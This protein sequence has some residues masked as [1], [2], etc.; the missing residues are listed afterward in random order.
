MVRGG[1]D[2]LAQKDQVIQ[3][4]SEVNA[5]LAAESKARHDRL[6]D[7]EGQLKEAKSGR[8]EEAVRLMQAARAFK[9]QLKEAKSGRE[10]E[11]VRLMQANP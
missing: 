11:A 10:E 6:L 1:P 3:T 5:Q 8:E 2:A 7:L 4:A 9:G